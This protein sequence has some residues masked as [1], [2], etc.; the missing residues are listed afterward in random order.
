MIKKIS[1]RKFHLILAA[2]LIGIFLGIN[3][4]FMARAAEPTYKYLDYFH[5]VFQ[6]IMT[7]YV[8]E[9]NIKEMFYGSI[10][11]MLKALDDPYSRFLDEE[12]YKELQ[13]MTTG[14]FVGVGIEISSENGDII[15]VTPIEESPA[16]EAG[17]MAGDSIVKINDSFVR[18]KKL[19][20]IVNM[21]K[22][23]PQSKVSLSIKR[24][25]IADFLDFE[26]ERAP[27]KIKSVKFD[28]IQEHSIGFIKII[29]FGSDTGKDVASAVRDLNKKGIK[30]LILDVRYN[31]G[32]LL[33]GATE[34]SDLFLEKG[35]VIV[36][37]RGR[38]GSGI[39]S[40]FKS[41][42]EPQYTGD[43][44]VL[45]NKGS[46]SASEILAGA[47]RDNKRGKL[48]GEKTFG[49]GSVQK[50]FNL[51]EDV[52]VAITVARYY[53]PSG[54]MIHKKG[55]AP[56]ISVP[57]ELFS[58]KDIE[59]LQKIEKNRILDS[60]V[61][62]DMA[63]SPETK[64]QFIEYLTSQGVTLSEKASYF[65]LK[66]KLHKYKKKPSYDL[67]FDTQLTEAIKYFNAK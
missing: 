58:N 11:G 39:L 29:N 36:T 9:P 3:F 66:N 28:V 45:I 27:I 33:T 15:V 19:S 55:I 18:G 63:F 17:I 37:T 4:S 53:T 25:G 52:G 21:I 50:S 43:L 8:D 7:D 22:G 14:K 46:A 61:K 51:D 65:I 42:N 44:I 64:K 40:E 47:I 59:A 5:R 34:I 16:M 49:K 23:I 67:E 2:F 20:E 54:E 41:E 24:E 56:D 57:M 35:R 13:E 31:P 48:L 38:E 26:L 32:G 10:R 62:K 12:A 1:E 30:K 6:I 60:F